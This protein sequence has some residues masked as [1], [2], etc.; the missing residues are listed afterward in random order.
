LTL[1]KAIDIAKSE[2]MTDK[3]ITA[4]VGSERYDAAPPEMEIDAR[5]RRKILYNV[6]EDQ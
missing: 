6:W 5:I 3:H 1:Q 2:E 4:I